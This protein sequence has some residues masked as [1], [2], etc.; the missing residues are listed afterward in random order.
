MLAPPGTKL[1]MKSI[2]K[3]VKVCIALALLCA[4]LPASAESADSAQAKAKLA[5]VR[6]RIAALTERI[7]LELKQRDVLNARLREADL[8]VTEKRRRLDS[9][10]AEELGAERRR[11][12]A[13][14]GASAQSK[15]AA[16][17]ARGI[18]RAGAG[19][20]HDRAAGAD[21]A[22]PESDIPGRG[23][24]HAG[25]LPVFRERARR[26]DRGDRRARRA[27]WRTGRAKRTDGRAA[28]IPRRRCEPRGRGLGAR[29]CGA[30]RG[31]R[32]S[33]PAGE[34]AAIRNSRNSSARS[35]L[36]ILWSRTSREYCRIFRSTRSS[37]SISCAASSPGRSRAE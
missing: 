34:R 31:I 26:E 19:S 20:V 30:R 11:E 23:G 33:R 27:H 16:G 22:P 12:R 35:R 18:G 9:L 10:H 7:S 8:A 6:A 21:E 36:W 1:P 2:P 25:V 4:S 37:G 29:A 32:R 24:T 14:P 5:A 15:C 3:H 13:S 17:R 28:Q